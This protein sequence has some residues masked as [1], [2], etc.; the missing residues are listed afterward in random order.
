M[1][2]AP[3]FLVESS[4]NYNIT[5]YYHLLMNLDFPLEFNR[6][7]NLTLP[8]KRE[9]RTR[10]EGFRLRVPLKFSNSRKNV[11]SVQLIIKRL[12]RR[13]FFSSE[14]FVLRA[15]PLITARVFGT[16]DIPIRDI[17]WLPLH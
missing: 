9:A 8:G 3:H 17:G 7:G 4:I 15:R 12:A 6:L 14:D 1:L 5:A 2:I 13:S 10:S 11:P 16:P